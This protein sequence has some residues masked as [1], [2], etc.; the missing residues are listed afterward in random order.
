MHKTDDRSDN[1]EK[2]IDIFG[3]LQKPR[4]KADQPAEHQERLFSDGQP[5]IEDTDDNLLF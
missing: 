3:N 4:G 2:Q 5:F 1:V